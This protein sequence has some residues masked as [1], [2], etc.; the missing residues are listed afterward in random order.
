M[1]SI[2]LTVGFALPNINLVITRSIVSDP[3]HVWSESLDDLSIED[4][5]VVGRGVMSVNANY[6]CVFSVHFEASQKIG[7]SSG[8]HALISLMYNSEIDGIGKLTM[9]ST[10]PSKSSLTSS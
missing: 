6:A 5:N 4:T 2:Q 8:V 3:L 9:T 1:I 7:A 10:I